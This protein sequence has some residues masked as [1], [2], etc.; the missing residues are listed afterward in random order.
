MASILNEISQWSGKLPYWEQAALE[1]VL[2]STELGDDDYEELLQY[3]LEDAGLLPQSQAPRPD[4]TFP[5][6]ATAEPP[7]TGK[8]LRLGK[9]SRLHNVNALVPDQELTFG[10]ALTAIFGANG[11]GKSGYARVIASAAFTRGDKQVL[12]D[13]TQPATDVEAMSAEIELTDG[14]DTYAL[15]YHVGDPCQQMRCFYVFDSTSVHAHLTRSNAMSFSPGGLAYLTRLADVTDQ[16][17]KRLQGE[18]EQRT[19]PS[20]F[21]ILF[22]GETEVSRLVAALDAETDVEALRHLGALSP[23]EEAEVDEA[24]PAHCPAQEREHRRADCGSPAGG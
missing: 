17:R 15:P 14:T 11:S 2:T 4:L 20:H 21:P 6:L 18:I 8:T 3:L 23:K 16:V 13:V 10:P 22:P 1:K 12:R 9:I 19:R 24:G 7:A 5:Q